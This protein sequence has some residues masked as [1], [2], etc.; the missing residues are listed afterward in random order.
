LIFAVSISNAAHILELLKEKS[1][2]EGF[3]NDFIIEAIELD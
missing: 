2:N 3:A 1:L